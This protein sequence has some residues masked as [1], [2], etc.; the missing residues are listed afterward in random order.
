M[1]LKRRTSGEQLGTWFY[2]I[3]YATTSLNVSL[4]LGEA[5]M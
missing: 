3:S 1:Q 4:H 2:L 5:I